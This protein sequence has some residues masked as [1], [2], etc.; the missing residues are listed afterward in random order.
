MPHVRVLRSG[1]IAAGASQTAWSTARAALD[2]AGLGDI[3][4]AAGAE[5]LSIRRA[6]V[7]SRKML[8]RP[9]LCGG[10]LAL[11]GLAASLK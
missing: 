11:P 1:F 7:G 2:L 3:P 10:R 8:R 4:R 5:A 9:E 6:F